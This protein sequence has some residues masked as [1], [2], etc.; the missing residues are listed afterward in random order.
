MKKSKRTWLLLAAGLGALVLTG[1]AE[2][3]SESVRLAADSC[4][5]DPFTPVSDLNQFRAGPGEVFLSDPQ[6]GG[7]WSRRA[8]QRAQLA[9][10]AAAADP[11]WQ[12]LADSWGIAEAAARAAAQPEIAASASDLKL[13]YA[14][15]TKD[16][17]CRIALVR[18][19]Y[20]L[21]ASL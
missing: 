12:P 21:S 7:D 18:I 13:S 17:Y 6:I 9:A 3:N 14:M 2:S 11:Y 5:S 15:V 10:R 19:G 20:K 8:K 1:C 16:V 4:A